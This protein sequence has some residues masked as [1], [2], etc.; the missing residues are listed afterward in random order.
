MEVAEAAHNLASTHDMCLLAASW[1]TS[2][3][4]IRDR[5]V[6]K[7]TGAFAPANL[8]IVDDSHRHAGHA[9]AHPDGG[10]ET[11]FRVS[12]ASAAFTGQGRV[13][14]QRRVYAVLAEELRDRVHA[15]E[16]KLRAPG[17]P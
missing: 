11:H 8:E 7:L 2:M 1:R 9:G 6:A 12:F 3:G 14:R 5:I 15:L 4:A 13:E 16:L 17:E 10:G